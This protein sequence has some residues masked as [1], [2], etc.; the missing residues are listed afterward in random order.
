[1]A[2]FCESRTRDLLIYVRTRRRDAGFESVFWQQT[3]SK[4]SEILH[5]VQSRETGYRMPPEDAG[6]P[7][8]KEE[9]SLLRAWIDAGAVYDTHWSF[10]PPKRPAIPTEDPQQWSTK[11]LDRLVLESLHK[12]ELAPNP[13][14]KLATLARRISLD[15]I[16]IPPN[17]ERVQELVSDPRPDALPP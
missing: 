11:S 15:L 3:N 9:I 1:M 10:V 5:R 14:A 2:P 16:G 12:A 8:S 4:A 6:E 13:R 17:P 7:L